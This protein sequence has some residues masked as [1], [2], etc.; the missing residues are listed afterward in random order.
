MNGYLLFGKFGAFFEYY[1]YYYTCIYYYCHQSRLVL[2]SNSD[3]YLLLD[4][5]T[6]Q[7][8][9]QVWLGYLLAIAIAI[10]IAS[11]NIIEAKLL[12]NI[13]LLDQWSSERE[14]ERERERSNTSPKI[15]RIHSMST[16]RGMN[17]YLMA[18]VEVC[19]SVQG[20]PIFVTDQQIPYVV[21]SL[22]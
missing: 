3:G 2:A 14:K 7:P 12:N 11:Q 17:A 4:Q 20:Y 15:L 10:A 16:R 19:Y 22:D 8:S 18:A 6:K 13:T 1:Q 5:A 21:I 9:N